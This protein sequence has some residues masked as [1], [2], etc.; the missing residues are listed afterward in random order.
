MCDIHSQM[1]AHILVLENGF[2]TRAN[3]DGTY[4]ITDVPPG[5]YELTA[6]HEWFGE[7]KTT[8]EVGDGQTVEAEVIFSSTS[9]APQP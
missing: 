2:F 3:D 7:V 8:V 4:S 9:E 5:Q 6:W 1:I